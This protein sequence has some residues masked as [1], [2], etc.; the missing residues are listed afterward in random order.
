MAS[1]LGNCQH[2]FVNP[3][4]YAIGAGVGGILAA[5]TQVTDFWTGLFCGALLGPITYY[6]Y[7]VTDFLGTDAWAQVARV[8]IAFFA[9]FAL[10]TIALAMF[11]A[12]ISFAQGSILIFSGVATAIALGILAVN[13]NCIRC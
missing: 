2:A 9:A 3:Y 7:N 11:G 6:I 5:A 13:R 4:P 10:G 8:A 12:K 1:C